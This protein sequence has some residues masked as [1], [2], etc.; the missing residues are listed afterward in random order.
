M[1]GVGFISLG[2]LTRSGGIVFLFVLPVGS[3]E[4]V[5]PDVI[6]DNALFMLDLLRVM[7]IFLDFSVYVFICNPS[8]IN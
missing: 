7:L 1:S 2:G 5:K 3:G 4:S 8:L 6:C